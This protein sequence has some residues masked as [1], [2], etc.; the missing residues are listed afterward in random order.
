MEVVF[1]TVKEDCLGYWH[2]LYLYY[3]ECLCWEFFF[4]SNPEIID[5]DIECQTPPKH[6][7]RGGEPTSLRTIEPYVL[8]LKHYDKVCTVII[9]KWEQLYI[10]L[11]CNMNIYFFF[12]FMYTKQ[13]Q[14]KRV[15]RTKINYTHSSVCMQCHVQEHM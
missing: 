9:T 1:F 6:G 5:C 2:L 11:N 12:L 3:R 7:G 15:S 13:I 8:S 14:N 10:K 4:K